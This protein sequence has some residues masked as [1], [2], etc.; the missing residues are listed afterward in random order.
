MPDD[1]PEEC[2]V[3]LTYMTA[4]HPSLTAVTAAPE[5]GKN[6]VAGEVTG[7]S[8][9]PASPVFLNPAAYPGTASTMIRKSR[10]HA[11]H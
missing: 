6:E 5:Y 7:I 10:N 4:K 3:S 2:T 11:L 9:R 8:Y 1:M